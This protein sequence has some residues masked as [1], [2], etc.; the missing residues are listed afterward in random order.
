[1]K[2]ILVLL[3][4][5]LAQPVWAGSINLSGFTQADFRLFSEDIGAA[6]SYKATTP[7]APLGTTGIDI[8]I[9]FTSTKISNQQSW[10]A[11]TGSSRS[12]VVLSKVTAHKGLPFGIDIGAFYATV[13]TT[14]V[15][16]YGGELRYA[17]LEGGVASPAIGIRGSMSRA[18]GVN[19][20][21]L[22]TTGLDA[23]ISKGFA[24]ITPYAGIGSVWVDST[25][26]G[27]A[28]LTKE[29]FRKAKTFA[30]ANINL[31][32][33]NL[34]IEYDKTGSSISYGIKMGF[35]Y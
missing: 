32:F 4:A 35:R 27:V 6:S 21:A 34:A 33:S 3:C 9:G 30:G 26:N 28:G 18:S 11:A 12:T 23:S 17:L 31:G 22:S 25:P 29:S 24:F 16:L 10:T 1:M 5:T 2:K 15:K 8:G 13:P 7:A 19:Q 20:L 14:N